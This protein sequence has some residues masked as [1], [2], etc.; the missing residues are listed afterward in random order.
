MKYFINKFQTFLFY[1]KNKTLLGRWNIEKCQKIIDIK[2]NLAN[3]DHCSCNEYI[4]NKKKLN[5]NETIKK[6]KT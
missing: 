5:Y 3:E 2:I 1:H 6:K 4:N